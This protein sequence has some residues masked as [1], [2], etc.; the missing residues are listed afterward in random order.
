M[1]AAPR[2]PI[3]GASCGNKKLKADEVTKDPCSICAERLG[4][5]IICRTTF[6]DAI[7]VSR[8][9]YPN[10]TIVEGYLPA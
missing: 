10:F 8:Y 7:P 9:Y 2:G 6:G 4:E 1:P 3:I 5:L